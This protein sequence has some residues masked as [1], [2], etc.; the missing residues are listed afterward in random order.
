MDAGD[1]PVILV[2]QIAALGKAE[3]RQG[4]G[5]FT[6]TEELCHIKFRRE[7]AVLRITCRFPVDPKIE[8]RFHPVK[9][10]ED[11]FP[12]KM[13]GE[14]EAP[15]VTSGGVVRRDVRRVGELA[16]FPEGG[17]DHVGAFS[18]VVPRVGDVGVDGLSK[19]LRLPAP[20]HRDGGEAGKGRVLPI[21]IPHLLRG[22]LQ[23]ELPLPVEGEFVAGQAACGRF[24]GGIIGLPA[25]VCG[26]TL[27]GGNLHPFP[28]GDPV[29][30]SPPVHIDHSFR[31]IV[32]R[33]AIVIRN[34]SINEAHLQA[35]LN[36][37]GVK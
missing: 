30:I 33:N 18:L 36:P 27:D 13:G 20:R 17:T 24:F 3:H 6:R 26:H 28:F 4:N 12:H 23:F 10:Q 9:T 34:Y 31:L 11:L 32:V 8:G 7:L 29:K 16:F 1:V 15:A 14:G 5:V 21:K 37:F 25:G 22:S 19:T 35:F 2:L